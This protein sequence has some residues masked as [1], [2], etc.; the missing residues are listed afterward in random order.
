MLS[1]PCF[2]TPR[3]SLL[4]SPEHHQGNRLGM[5]QEP[6]QSQFRKH[7]MIL[8]QACRTQ[9]PCFSG[10]GGVSLEITRPASTPPTRPDPPPCHPLPPSPSPVT[11]SHAGVTDKTGTHLPAINPVSELYLQTPALSPSPAEG[12]GA[13]ASSYSQLWCAGTASPIHPPG[14]LETR[15]WPRAIGAGSQPRSHHPPP[16]KSPCR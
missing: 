9:S 16:Q 5:I 6:G 12:P 10:F 2:L 14:G 8:F 13:V 11:G 15:L 1:F 7:G 3:R 4:L